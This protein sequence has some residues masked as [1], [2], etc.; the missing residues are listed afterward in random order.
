M[1]RIVSFTITNEGFEDVEAV[2]RRGVG[3]TKNQISQAKFRENGIC[4]NGTRCRIHEK[5]MPGDC[6]CVKLEAE[7]NDAEQLTDYAVELD[8]LYEDED[9]LLVNKPAG[10]AIHPSHGHYQDTLANAVAH[11]YRKKMQSIQVRPVGRLDLETSGIVVFA[12]NQTAAA[13]LEQQKQDGIFRKEYVAVV[14]GRMERTQGEV[15]ASIGPV[16]GA[17]NKMQICEGGK[18]AY[19]QYQVVKL[20]KDK[21]QGEDAVRSVLRL[22]LKTGRTHQIRVHMAS[23]GHSLVGDRI[24]G[25]KVER[26]P[27]RAALHAYRVWLEQPFTKEPLVVTAAIPE[28]MGVLDVA[29]QVQSSQEKDQGDFN[30]GKIRDAEACQSAGDGILGILQRD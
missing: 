23:L 19:T 2:L 3:L 8:I 30:N 18:P 26:E 1:E 24:Y 25:S 7:G 13:R 16:P 9:L 21:E 22:Q 12:K 29:V 28:D 15:S 17:L 4:I 20:M 14:Q 11:Y 27:S 10:M 5:V 6:I